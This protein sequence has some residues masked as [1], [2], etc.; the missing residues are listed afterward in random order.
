M[1]AV[2]AYHYLAADGFFPVHCMPLQ[3]CIRH[4]CLQGFASRLDISH[5]KG[6]AA[7]QPLVVSANI[8]LPILGSLG[9]GNSKYQ[10]SS[11]VTSIVLYG[12][13]YSIIARWCVSPSISF[14]SPGNAKLIATWHL[15]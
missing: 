7:S 14:A 5:D 1:P 4:T 6:L 8:T 2:R 15:Y 12:Q 3:G 10:R 9:N 13:D 11:G